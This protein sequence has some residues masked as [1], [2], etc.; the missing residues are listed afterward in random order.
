MPKLSE[1]Q[2]RQARKMFD[3]VDAH[4]ARA[5]TMQDIADTFGVSRATMYRALDQNRADDIAKCDVGKHG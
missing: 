5:H 4:G 1:R 3:E 2:I